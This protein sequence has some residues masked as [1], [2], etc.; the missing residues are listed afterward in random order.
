MAESPAV[1]ADPV[2]EAALLAELRAGSDTAYERLIR[3][4]GGRMMAVARRLLRNEEDASDA[5]QEAFLGAFRNLDQFEGNSRIATWLHRIVVNAA[6]MKLRSKNRRP[7]TSI[8][9]LLPRFDNNGYQEA[10]GRSW[11]PDV[12]DRLEER[13]TRERVHHAI[14]KLPD[15]YR[16]VLMLRDI[17]QLDTKET[18]EILGLSENAVKTRL[19]RARLALKT[20]L[21][22]EFGRDDL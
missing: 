14:G 4:Y 2:E 18:G 13:E 17:E 1:D 12:S 16:A 8:E 9:D 21:D 11:R 20:L 19:H 15:V 3:T 6:L 5:V 10:G 22:S 7:E